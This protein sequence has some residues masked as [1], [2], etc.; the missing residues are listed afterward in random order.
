MHIC[1]TKKSSIFNDQS[2][3]LVYFIELLRK[4]WNRWGHFI[5]PDFFYQNFLLDLEFGRKTF[6]LARNIYMIFQS[7]WEPVL[8]Q[9]I[10]IGLE[11][12]LEKGLPI[13]LHQF[14]W[15]VKC[16]KDVPWTPIFAHTRWVESKLHLLSSD[17]YVT[18]R[19]AHTR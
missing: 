8:I 11:A 1:K 19:L 6:G 12:I 3:L 13:E 7:G 17:V 18:W 5:M 9:R 4:V 15:P 16:Q 14:L 10:I 2:E